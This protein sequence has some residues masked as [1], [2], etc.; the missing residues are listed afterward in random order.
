MTNQVS[1]YSHTL[2]ST[3]SYLRKYA[4]QADKQANG[5]NGNGVIDGNEIKT[6]KNIVKQKTG[7]DFDFSSMKP[8]QNKTIAVQ[9]N[10]GFIF[11]NTA[12]IAKKY[13]NAVSTKT[14]DW[15]NGKQAG[16]DLLVPSRKTLDIPYMTDD[17]YKT[18]KQSVDKQEQIVNAKIQKQNKAKKQQEAKELHE[19]CKSVFESIADWFTGLVKNVISD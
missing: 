8:V 9:D 12:E 15:M 16:H 1:G 4:E 2:F 19:N 13:G 5:G 3:G 7:Y 14:I 6:F 18:S 10:N 17:D 11:K